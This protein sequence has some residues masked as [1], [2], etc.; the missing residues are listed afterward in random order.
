[1]PKI[2]TKKQLTK[3]WNTRIKEIK[4]IYNEAKKHQKRLPKFEE[5][6]GFKD[7]EKRKKRSLKRWG[8]RKEINARNRE[9]YAV[10][11][12]VEQKPLDNFMDEMTVFEAFSGRGRIFE[13][14]IIKANEGKEFSGIV[15]V[16]HYKSEKP[17]VHT[18]LEYGGFRRFINALLREL[19]NKEGDVYAAFRWTI[20]RYFLVEENR[21]TV[22]YIFKEVNDAPNNET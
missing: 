7:M 1:M 13:A 19:Y 12:E 21:L 22:K 10:R 11:K 14:A 6:A 18:F 5:T 8:N 20:E 16:W 17:I 4:R 9:K 2:K 15:E 3:K